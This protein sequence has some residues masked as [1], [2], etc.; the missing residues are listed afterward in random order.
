[1]LVPMPENSGLGE[2]SL[3]AHLG[4]CNRLVDCLA[5]RHRCIPEDPSPHPRALRAESILAP[6]SASA[7]R[8]FL[9]SRLLAFAPGSVKSISSPPCS[10]NTDYLTFGFWPRR[11]FLQYPG[12]FLRTMK[13]LD[14]S[15]MKITSRSKLYLKYW[16]PPRSVGNACPAPSPLT[17]RRER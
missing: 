13:G 14:F 10:A 3:T 12:Q 8:M 6:A 9:S 11:S 17:S 16:N 15:K 1:M 5:H 7:I 2:R 4:F